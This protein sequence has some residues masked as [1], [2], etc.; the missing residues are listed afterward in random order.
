M[1]FFQQNWE[2]TAETAYEEMFVQS[3][4]QYTQQILRS[5]KEEEETLPKHAWEM[6]APKDQGLCWETGRP[7]VTCWEWAVGLLSLQQT[8]TAEHNK[9][10][11]L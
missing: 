8:K 9:L 7:K 5:A 11:A 4:G 6:K 10:W 1:E 3:Q 2:V